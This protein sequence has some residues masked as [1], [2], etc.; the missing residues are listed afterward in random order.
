L[1]KRLTLLLPLILISSVLAIAPYVPSG[2]AQNTGTV[3]IAASGKATGCPGSPPTVGPAAAGS[4]LTVGV[5]I[6]N[7]DPMNSFDIYVQTDPAVLNPTSAAVGPLIVTPSSTT[8]CI[9]NAATTGS[10]VAGTANGPGVVEVATTEGSGSN[11]CV[12]LPPCSGL[13]FNITYTVQSATA[14]TQFSYPSAGGCFPSSVGTSSTCVL[15]LDNIG[16]VLPENVQGGSF[17]QSVAATSLV[18][19]VTGSDGNLYWSPFISGAWGAWSPLNGQTPSSPTLCQS[20]ATTVELLVRGS[21]NALYHKTFTSGSPG[22]FSATWDK[23]PT[24]IV[25][26]QPVCQVIGTTMYVVVRGASGELWF[27]TETLSTNTWAATWTDLNGFSPSTPALAATPAVSRLDLVVRGTDNQIYHKAFTGGTWATAWDTSNRSP[28]ADKTLATPAIVSDGNQLHV[29]VIGATGTLYY[30]TLSF[31]GAWSTYQSL[32]GSTP[33]TPTLIIDSALTLHLLV[34]G[35]D[36]AV[37]EKAH[38][39][40]GA[41]DAQWSFAGGITVGSPAAAMVGTTLY[42]IVTGTNGNLWY[43]SLTGTT[44]AGYL[45][46]NGSARISTASAP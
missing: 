9:N 12:N 37:Y 39:N 26:D 13:A 24:G 42:I 22:S 36:N 38:P 30:A 46:M 19:V 45:T 16:N 34:Q 23:N 8:I 5:F 1:N 21:D 41:W 40:G 18:S 10:C 28:V 31:T 11:E 44:W 7:S 14:S 6:A 35:N 33:V 32:V 43:N 4:S 17:V 27:T 15:V 3:C 2:H 25:L 20:S 29:V